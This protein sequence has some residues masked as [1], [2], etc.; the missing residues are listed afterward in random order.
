MEPPG[1]K[2]LVH[3]PTYYAVRWSDS[4]LGPGEVSAPVTLLGWKVEFQI[5]D[6]EYNVRFGDGNASGWTSSRGGRYPDGDIVHAY[7]DTGVM[8]VKAD[9]RLRGKFRIDGGPWRDIEG[10]ADLDNEPVSNLR[11]VEAKPRLVDD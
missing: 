10:V 1:Q 3:L 8:P 11:V 9:A 7:T 5:A 4:G 6:P 2:T